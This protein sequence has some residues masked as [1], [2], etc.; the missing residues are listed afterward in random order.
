SNNPYLAAK[1]RFVGQQIPVQEFTMEN[2]GQ[3][4]AR[5]VWSLN[6]MALATYAKLG[7]VP[8]LLTADST[9]GHEVVFGIG[10]AMIQTSRLSAKER[11]VGITTVFTGDGRYYVNNISSAV[12]ADEYFETLLQNL[13]TTMDRV[14]TD[15]AWRPKDT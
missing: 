2:L 9:I 1:A 7:G 11:M 12:T 14:K 10:S 15:F 4:D 13:R 6:N 5:I 3:P 8:W